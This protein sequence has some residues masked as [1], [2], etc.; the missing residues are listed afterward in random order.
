ME[1]DQQRH[2]DSEANHDA[3]PHTPVAPSFRLIVLSHSRLYCRS[4]TQQRAKGRLA[5]TQ[6]LRMMSSRATLSQIFAGLLC[7]PKC[8]RGSQKR[9]TIWKAMNPDKLFDYLEGR[10][11]PNERSALEER[12]MS[13]KQLQRELAVARHIHAGMRG[14]S[15]EV[16]LPPQ[17]DVSEQGHKMAIRVGVAFMVL[18]AVNVGIGLW[19]ILRHETS[20]PNR[21]LLEK[22]MR[23][24]IAK[25]IERAAATLTPA[26]NALGVSEITIPVANGKLDAVADEVVAIASRS[27][28]SATKGVKDGNHLSVLVDVPSNR[29]SD[30]RNALASISNARPETT[31]ATATSQ[32]TVSPESTPPAVE[33]KSF[34]VKI[35]EALSK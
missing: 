32:A 25:S 23:E 13:D 26:P 1:N 7:H 19:F 12:L 3:T 2:A 11:S 28:G 17:E 24:Q 29:E 9:P 14:D 18:V 21:P 8:V 27:G 30:F 34:V 22:Q 20:N 5:N 31:P 35:V 15:R 6:G 33:R 10:L 4:R 16:E